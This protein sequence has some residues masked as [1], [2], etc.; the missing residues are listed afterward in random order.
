MMRRLEDVGSVDARELKGGM[1]RLRDDE[2]NG[3]V[4]RSGDG[5][6]IGG[7]VGFEDDDEI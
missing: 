5:K 7:D 3:E 2:Q 4:R 6:E 1:R